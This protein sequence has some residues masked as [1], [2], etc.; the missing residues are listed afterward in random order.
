MAEHAAKV[1]AVTFA[2]LA[3]VA[4]A[5]EATNVRWMVTGAWGRVLLLETVY[6]LPAGRATQDVDFAVMVESW[7]HYH[8]LVADICRDS[9]F[10]EDSKQAQRIRYRT[11]FYLDLVPFGG[12]ESETQQIAWPPEGDF[13]MSVAGFRDALADAVPVWVND[14]LLVPVVSPAGLL[15]LKLLAWNERRDQK[16]GRDASDIAYVLRHAAKLISEHRLFEEHLSV[17]DRLGYDIDLAAAYVL[18]GQIRA[19]TSA[20][21]REQ[22]L[23]VL[24]PLLTEAEDAVLVRDT[25]AYMPSEDSERVGARLR[26]LKAGF[27]G[28]AGH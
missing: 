16:S 10:M 7:P 28:K 23:S 14:T 19:L 6:G 2:L 17:V 24:T 15:L 12:V 26:Q 25:S 22:L 3:A 11:E 9:D 5:A 8:R 27:E 13:V 4:K 18:G 21:T 1:D 20:K